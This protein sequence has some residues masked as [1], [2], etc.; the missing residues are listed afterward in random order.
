V[1]ISNIYIEFPFTISGICKTSGSADSATGRH[2]GNWEDAPHFKG[3]MNYSWSKKVP[4]FYSVETIWADSALAAIEDLGVKSE[5]FNPTPLAAYCLMKHPEYQR[6]IRTHYFKNFSKKNKKYYAAYY[7][8]IFHIVKGPILDLV[9]RI[10]KKVSRKKIDF[11]KYNNLKNIGVA[12][13]KLVKHL[14][15]SNIDFGIVLHNLNN[16]EK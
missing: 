16:I 12:E 15:E 9:K 8:L 1:S 2:T 11:M 7:K 5:N 10:F 4:K 14:K 6:I 3:H 13:K